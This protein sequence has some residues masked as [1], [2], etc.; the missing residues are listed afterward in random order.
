MDIIQ[1]IIAGFSAY[2][3][4]RTF[5]KQGENDK[6]QLDLAELEKRAKQGEFFPQ[7]VV[8]AHHSY[9]PPHDDERI[10][11][12]TSEIYT[13]NG[14]FRIMSFKSK[15]IGPS[16]FI[17]DDDT[18]DYFDKIIGKDIKFEYSFWIDEV[19]LVQHALEE[20]H[21]NGYYEHG[22]ENELRENC[23]IEI[24]MEISDLIGH[25]YILKMFISNNNNVK[26]NSMKLKK[27]AN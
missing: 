26:I 14:V 13:S 17:H 21:N 11:I 22:L 7:V 15:I 4:F 19:V 10:R 8:N 16:L 20:E 12:I 24:E 25:E 3:L 18:P 5:K 2:L 1:M 6:R 27:P 23:G 9:A